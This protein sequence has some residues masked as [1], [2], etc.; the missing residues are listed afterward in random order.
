MRGGREKFQRRFLQ[1]LFCKSCPSCLK[2]VSG[3][4]LFKQFYS[5]RFAAA[6][7][8]GLRQQFGQCVFTQPLHCRRTPATLGARR[9]A[10]GA[11]RSAL[12]ARRSALANL[13]L[14]YYLNRS[15]AP[16]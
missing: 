9:S 16:R 11:R 6:R 2:A 13:W 12:G 7:A 1:R 5:R 4:E 3:L 8:A 14:H 10:L 15:K